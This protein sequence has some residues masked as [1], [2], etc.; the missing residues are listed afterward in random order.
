MCEKVLYML[1]YIIV[2]KGGGGIVQITLHDGPNRDICAPHES[3][4][5]EC[6]QRK[7]MG[8]NI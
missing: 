3:T 7:T 5:I 4:K 2:R 8:L 6:R 1:S